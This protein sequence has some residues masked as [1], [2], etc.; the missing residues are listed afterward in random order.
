MLKNYINNS[1]SQFADDDANGL[2]S[3][4]Q[5]LRRKKGNSG[6]KMD[7]KNEISSQKKP[8]CFLLPC[9]VTISS[10]K[11]CLKD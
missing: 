11:R 9:F 2:I 8:K 6:L 10:K 5:Y 3:W 4:N 1:L 7:S